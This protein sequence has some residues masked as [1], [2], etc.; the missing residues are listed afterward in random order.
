MNFDYEDFENPT[1]YFNDNQLHFD[2]DVDR[3]T[4]LDWF[5]RYTEIEY[6]DD[7]I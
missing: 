7:Y 2:L 3:I 6:A 5:L 1:S 4:H